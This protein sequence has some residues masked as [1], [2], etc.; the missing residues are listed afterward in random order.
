[1]DFNASEESIASTFTLQNRI[2]KGATGSSETLA[3]LPNYTALEE[4]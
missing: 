4:N 3:D 2:N 1:M